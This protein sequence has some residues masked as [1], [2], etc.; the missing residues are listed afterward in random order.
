MINNDIREIPANRLTV[1]P[2]VQRQV[3][4]GRVRKIAA[5]WDSLQVGVLTVSKRQALFMGA[6][7]D[8]DASE[9]FVVLDGQT[10]LGAFR[11]VC[12]EDTNQTLTCQVYTGLTRQEEAA[13]FLAHNDRK[14]VLTR[15]RFRLSMVAG[16]TW[17]LDIHDIAA[18]HGWYVAGGE[19]L[20]GKSRV[21][22]AIGA[23]ERVYRLDDGATLKKTFAVIATAWNGSPSAVSSETLYGVGLLLARHSLEAKQLH[24]L[25]TKLSKTPLGVY[26][27][28]VAADR[29]RNG[30]TIAK[31]AY[32]YTVAIYNRGRADGNRI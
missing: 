2:E 13:M 25:T 12:G 4:P 24:G 8:V 1:D 28:D 3:D 26:V 10:R 16:E 5:A 23:A 30:G 19:K 18:R 27:G 15:D 17:A 29:R 32:E 6:P 14:A 21:F 9:E 31:A 20:P 22:T 11:E 7:G